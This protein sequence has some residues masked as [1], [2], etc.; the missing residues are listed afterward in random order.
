[1]PTTPKKKRTANVALSPTSNRIKKS[2]T[3]RKKRTYQFAPVDNLN[4]RDTGGKSNVLKSIPVSQIRNTAI[5]KNRV[6]QSLSR[7]PIDEIVE[8]EK[9][10]VIAKAPILKKS[11]RKI[12]P[13]KETTTNPNQSE[14]VIWDYSPIKKDYSG[15]SA[16]SPSKADDPPLEDAAQNPSSTPLVSNKWKTILNFTN[17]DDKEMVGKN[18]KSMTPSD[19]SI[20]RETA[21]LSNREAFNI[22][23]ILGNISSKTTKLNDIPSSPTRRG[24]YTKGTGHIKDENSEDDANGEDDSLIDILT[25]RFTQHTERLRQ[26]SIDNVNNISPSKKAFELE[27]KKE[28]HVSLEDSSD[29][30]KTSFNISNS[31]DSLL[32][33]LEDFDAD[34]DKQNNTEEK[35][36]Q[37]EEL[38]SEKLRMNSETP[39]QEL[40]EYIGLAHCAIKR[41]GVVRLVI[42]NVRELQLPK[43]G[44]QKILLCVDENGDNSSVIVRNPWVYLKFERGDVIHIIE[45]KNFENKRLLSNDENPKTRLGNDNLLILNPDLLLSATS[46]GSSMEC[47]RRGVIQ[48]I[49]K[50]SRGEPSI[51][52]TIGNIVHELL[53]DSFKYMLTHQNLTMGYI[54]E[55]LDSLLKS[56]SFDILICNQSTADVRK[57]IMEEHVPNISEFVNQFISKNNYGRYVSVSGLRKTQPLSISDV[58]DIE[59]NIWSSIYGLKGYLDATVEVKVEMGKTIAPFEVK[60][61]KFRSVAHEAQGLIYTLLLNDKYEI[62]IDFFLLYYTRDKTMTK[63]PGSLHSVKHVLMLRNQMASNLKH[64]LHEIKT[65]DKIKMELPPL[66]G[67]SICDN[68]YVKEMCMVLNKLVEDGTSSESGLRP[69]EY[70][71]LTNHLLKNIDRYRQFF[72]KFNDLITKEE[73]SISSIN[74]KLFLL[75]SKTRE[76]EDGRCLSNLIIDEITEQENREGSYIYMFR[77]HDVTNDAR[78]ML[79]SQLSANDF[80]LI[81]DEEGHFC[82]SQGI[83]VSIGTDYIN[84]SLKRKLLNN[85]ITSTEDKKISIQSVVNP[86]LDVSDT[87]LT[88]NLV[89]YRIDKNE[90]QQSLSLARFNILNLFL[91]A[92]STGDVVIDENTGETRILKGSEGGDARMRDFLVDNVSPK[93]VPDN[94][95]PII[96]YQKYKDTRMNTDQLKAIDHVM[97]A[98][99][100]ALILGMPGSGKTTVIAEIIKILVSQG[101]SIL[102]TSYTHSAVDNILLKLNELNINIM[103]LGSPHKTHAQT[104]QY[105]PNYDSIKTYDE[106]LEMINNVSVVATTCLGIQDVLFTLRKKDFDYV[107]LDE[108]SQISIPVALGPLRFGNKFIMVGDHYQLPPLIKNEAARIGGLEESLFKVFCERQPQS[109]IE[110]TYQYRMCGDIVTLSNLLIYE[111]KLKCGTEEVFNQKMIIPQI[112]PLTHFKE[113]K[114]S[115]SW[116]TD[117]LDPKKKVLFLD[118][119]NC[120][121]ICEQYESDNVTNMG[122]NEIVR[123]CVEGMLQCGVSSENIGVMTLYR[124]Q[125]RLLQKTFNSMYFQGLEILTA[126]QFQGRDKDCIIISMVRSNSQLN[127]GSLLKELRRVNV[128]MTRAKSKLIIVGSKKTIC[129]ISEIKPL[130]TLLEDKG[131]IYK[132]PKD[133]LDIYSFPR[134]TSSQKQIGGNKTGAKRITADSRLVKNKPII[135]QALSEI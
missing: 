109:V 132:L 69:G 1:M 104:R 87:L 100:Y 124:A 79:H 135:K 93:F 57:Q 42:L 121:S 130:M 73:S 84:V 66:V 111:N 14:H 47:L 38:L 65:T 36:A 133:C 22:D 64:Q 112:E 41:K 80:V 26:D 24:S 99:D 128:A 110:L 114:K 70:E 8:E 52:M 54:E 21:S 40:S 131:W 27:T 89:T 123:Q 83:V 33:Y 106:F 71:A 20:N 43:I 15:N 37:V 59:E 28:V 96:S 13:P 11:V 72:L 39:D 103:R 90:L 29:K 68:C 97:R 91:P 30:D 117:I 4:T 51:V 2:I 88:Q 56:F 19:Y 115:Q 9:P 74:N 16:S 67:S 6:E 86:S 18:E 82:L 129:N 95:P 55:K 35:V 32:A 5:S 23:D 119:D 46:V 31:S 60:T 105:L 94:E 125:L 78:S 17:I 102:L 126:D 50:D 127:G 98:E 45:G 122:E 12:P 10:T 85:R 3:K 81:S 108:A 61:G 113:N 134:H 34:V 63:Y 25:Q 107:I 53:Q 44:Q 76:L 92:V 101:K 58:I 118:Y 120:T 49:F 48:A 62:P 116:L 7:I 77:R 75:D